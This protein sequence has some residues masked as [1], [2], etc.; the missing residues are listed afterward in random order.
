MHFVY[1]YNYLLCFTT[2]LKM[3][4][5]GDKGDNGDKDLKKHESMTEKAL[6]NLLEAVNIK[7][8]ILIFY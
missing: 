6:G 3:Q 7:E 2:H 4:Y 1:F 5:H 8:Y